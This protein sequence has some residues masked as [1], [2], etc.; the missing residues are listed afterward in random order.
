VWLLTTLNRPEACQK[1]LDAFAEHGSSLGV[2]W[3]DGGDYSKLRLPQGWKLHIGGGGIAASF[4]WFYEQFP[5]APWYGWLADDMIPA[6]PGFDRLLAQTTE[7]NYFVYCNGGKHKSPFR[8]PSKPPVTIPGA[9]MWGGDLV[10]EMGWWSP[11]WSLYTCIDEAWKKLAFASG[12]ARYRHDVVVHHYH[13]SSGGRKRDKTDDIGLN[14]AQ[15]DVGR[16]EAWL[17]SKH[18][19]ECVNR[20]KRFTAKAGAVKRT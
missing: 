17:Q 19:T 8:K 16:L 10:R 7:G 14:R 11:P 13:W 20:I 1:T 2:V 18:F 6:T 5:N 3:V 12:V 15:A 9:M 4:N